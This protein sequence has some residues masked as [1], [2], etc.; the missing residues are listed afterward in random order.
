M[1][2]A[3][4]IIEGFVCENVKATVQHLSKGDKELYV[5]NV[6]VPGRREGEASS[7]F[8]CRAWGKRAMIAEALAKPKAYVRV[9]GELKQ[10]IDQVVDDTT[11]EVRTY[12]H[13]GVIINS[14]DLPRTA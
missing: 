12:E 3:N 11:G 13:I 14:V 1:S 4:V 2:R 9:E 8:E 6:C 7:F 5:F 10:K